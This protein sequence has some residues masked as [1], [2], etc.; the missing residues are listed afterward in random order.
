VG[1]GFNGVDV[2]ISA[3][4][5]TPAPSTINVTANAVGGFPEDNG[6]FVVP[7]PIIGETGD[8]DNYDPNW[9]G[10]GED[11]YAIS[12]GASA[13]PV[14]F[15]T[16]P[17]TGAVGF[18]NWVVTSQDAVG[19]GDL[20]ILALGGE[21]SW[22]ATSLTLND[23]GSN[24]MLYA[25]FL[26]DSLLTDWQNLTSINLSGTKGFVTLTGAETTAQEGSSSSSFAFGGLLTDTGTAGTAS[27]T[28]GLK[29]VGGLGNSFYDLSGMNLTSAGNAATSIDGG[30]NTGGNSEVAFNNSVVANASA[31]NPAGTAITISHLQILDD[32]G[33]SQ[34]G[35]I[36]MN[37]FIGLGPLNVNYALI[38]EDSPLGVPPGLPF[39][40]AATPP[41]VSANGV[42]PAGYQLL[43]LL[44]ADGSTAVTQTNNLFVYIGPTQFAINAQDMANGWVGSDPT[45]N[46]VTLSVPYFTPLQVNGWNLTIQGESVQPNV[47]TT[48]TLKY[49]VSDDGVTVRPGEQLEGLP[50]IVLGTNTFTLSD[51]P[52][53]QILNYTNV[54]FY[55]PFE[56]LLPSASSTSTDPGSIYHN[57]VVLGSESFTDA[58]VVLSFAN[59]QFQHA[60]L[61]FF[62]NANDTGG[63]DPGGPDNLAL[64]DTNF[65]SNPGELH[66][67]SASIGVDTVIVDANSITTTITDFGAGVFEIGA[68][69][70]SSLVATTTSHLIQDVSATLDYFTADSLTAPQGIDVWGSATGQNLLQGTS[71]EVFDTGY[72]AAAVEIG[73]ISPTFTQANGGT[74]QDV[75]VS[76]PNAHGGEGGSWGNDILNGGAGNNGV[77]LTETGGASI[78][79]YT[80]NSG[81]NFFPEGGTDIVNIG[82]AFSAA[83][84]H[85]ALGAANSTVWFG[86]FD[87]SNSG[88]YLGVLA[89]SGVGTIYGQAITHIAGGA[90]S[91]VDGYGGGPAVINGFE[92][93]VGNTANRGDI[94]NLDAPD[95]AV[96]LSNGLADNGLV[97]ANGAQLF[98]LHNADATT[99]EVGSTT[100]NAIT[101]GAANLILDAFGAYQ[102]S[103]QLVAGL[104]TA[105]AISGL[106]IAANTTEHL[107]I[108]YQ[109]TDTNNTNADVGVNIADLTLTTGATALTPVTSTATATAAHALT[110]SATDLMTLHG[111]GLTGVVELA[112]LQTGHNFHFV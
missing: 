16:T 107:L 102:N 84:Q 8:P 112:Q 45:D 59:G 81:D 42:I 67:S 66:L 82:G 44:D 13:G 53:V 105:G 95:W 70:A 51:T 63:S 31:G 43:Q 97:S 39:T 19:I 34:G 96:G 29:I 73:G 15:P 103:S 86:M 28:A 62:D 60:S 106:T 91:Y 33:P 65:V 101:N 32:T 57:W 46:V 83:N 58:P 36:N 69:D 56:S 80:G 111:V 4:D 79:P 9:I 1:N 88:D 47:N 87:I 22:S 92:A 7:P 17:S 24:T 104:Q 75:L 10:Y 94:I 40:S 54:D 64:G 21:G 109:N 50:A 5:F 6:S 108:A 37:D 2:D 55:L 27:E 35:W 52:V 30:H 48:D 11:A 100:G 25:T 93:F 18:T 77:T 110:L 38:A 26:S 74:L 90:E 68:T 78:V 12:A 85:A 20:N 98:T 99:F 41:S 49:Y 14:N 71:G 61:N 23:D 72:G 89:D 3:A 76:P